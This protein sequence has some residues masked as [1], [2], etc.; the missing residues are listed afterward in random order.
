MWAMFNLASFMI[1]FAISPK[2]IQLYFP[3]EVIGN[4]IFVNDDIQAFYF[5]QKKIVLTSIPYIIFS[6]LTM[7]IYQ[8]I[9][10]H[11]IV[12]KITQCQIYTL[13]LAF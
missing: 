7:E 9:G 10:L 8:Y 3:V 5:L 13:V 4:N 2:K 6:L 1:L 12:Y 11:M